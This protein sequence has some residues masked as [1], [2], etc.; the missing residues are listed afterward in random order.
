MVG[1]IGHP[2]EGLDVYAY[3]GMER[4]DASFFNVGCPFSKPHP[5]ENA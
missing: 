3:A 5:P 2:W 1:L 4:A